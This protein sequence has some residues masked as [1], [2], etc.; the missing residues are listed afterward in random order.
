M[1]DFSEKSLDAPIAGSLGSGGQSTAG[2]GKTAAESFSLPDWSSN[3]KAPSP[4]CGE[5]WPDRFRSR[6]KRD[7]GRGGGFRNH[8][9]LLMP[10]GEIHGIH[11]GSE[12]PLW[13]GPL[14]V[15]SVMPWKG[16]GTMGWQSFG[17]LGPF[18]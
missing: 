1:I 15:L 2:H 4:P 13:V 10:L 16:R 5:V 3:P 17:Y 8:H 14:G 6:E 12:S 7:F 11:P 18:R 9:L